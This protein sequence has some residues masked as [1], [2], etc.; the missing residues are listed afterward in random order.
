MCV[1]SKRVMLSFILYRIRPNILPTE[2]GDAPWSSSKN[3]FDS[4]KFK[5]LIISFFY[6]F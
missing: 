5:N 1:L 6:I 3:T 4:L 2:T